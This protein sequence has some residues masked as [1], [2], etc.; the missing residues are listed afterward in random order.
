[1]GTL[2]KNVFFLHL[3]CTSRYLSESFAIVCFGPF[4]GQTQVT[5]GGQLC[6]PAQLTD[7]EQ[8]L[9]AHDPHPGPPQR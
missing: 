2:G 6:F 1:M 4:V 3:F 8:H 7:E 5:K 9:P